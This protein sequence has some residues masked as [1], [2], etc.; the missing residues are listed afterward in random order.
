MTYTPQTLTDFNPRSPRGGATRAF[1]IVAHYVCV[2]QSTLPTRGSDTICL[3]LAGKSQRFQ[4]TLPTRG[5]DEWPLGVFVLS[6]PISIHAPHEGERLSSKPL[7]L[8]RLKFQ[9]TLPTR[10]SDLVSPL[11]R[12]ISKTLFQSTL[13]TRGSDPP[14]AYT[15]RSKRY[16]FQSTLPTRGSDKLEKW[17]QE[18]YN[19][20]Q[21][22]LPTRGSDVYPV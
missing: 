7:P 2:F 10:G 17:E 16:L 21:S 14:L 4:S 19:A 9:S 3:R 8:I 15:M 18:F 6:S 5:S 20:F 22:T 1:I 12:D 13:P 11:A